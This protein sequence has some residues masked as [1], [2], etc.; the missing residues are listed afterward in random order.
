MV[1]LTGVLA[2]YLYAIEIMM[3]P[4]LTSSAARLP[5]RRTSRG[6]HASPTNKTNFAL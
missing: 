6:K 5:T 2:Q 3:L 1:N 4:L